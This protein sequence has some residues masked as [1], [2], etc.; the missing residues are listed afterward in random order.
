[1]LIRPYSGYIK[2]FGIDILNSTQDNLSF[3]KDKIGVLFQSGGLISSLTVIQNV[4]FPLKEKTDLPDSIIYELSILKLSL[5]NFP[6]DYIN[7]F[8]N[9]LSGGMLK[10]ASLARAL[11]METDIL[12]LDEPTSGLDPVSCSLFN[13]TIKKINKLLGI[14]IVLIT[15]DIFTIKSIVD[16]MLVILKGKKS[17]AL[18]KKS[19]AEFAVL[20]S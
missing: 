16:R 10:R 8:P 1:M 2:I 13:K 20:S 7:L 17:I 11:V 5:A 4:S 3:V 19:L 15:H 14:T 12:F 6:L 9:E 18:S